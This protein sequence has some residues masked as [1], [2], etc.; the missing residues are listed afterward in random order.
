MKKL[1]ELYKIVLEEFQL[2][3]DFICII[4]MSSYNLCQEEKKLLLINFKR[5]KPTFFSKFWWNKSYWGDES[6][7]DL[8]KSGMEQRELYLKY[9]IKKYESTGN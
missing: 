8:D 4:I 5:N 6:W 9:L 2:K 3:R 1:S 7:W